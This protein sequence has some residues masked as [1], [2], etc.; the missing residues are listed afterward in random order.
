M[1]GI[2]GIYA[3]INPDFAC[4][5]VLKAYHNSIKQLWGC[6][7]ADQWNTNFRS[8]KAPN[9]IVAKKFAGDLLF[10]SQIAIHK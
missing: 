5:K 9:K 3:E 4:Q 1:Y 2:K 6:H 10:C 8:P 7:G